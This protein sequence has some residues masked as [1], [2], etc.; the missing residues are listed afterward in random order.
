MKIICT[1]IKLWK[2]LC[3]AK[4]S[5]NLSL[6]SKTFIKA[7]T[8]LK[9]PLCSLYLWLHLNWFQQ[10]QAIQSYCYELQTNFTDV[11]HWLQSLMKKVAKKQQSI[12]KSLE[13]KK[14]LEGK[15]ILDKIYLSREKEIRF[16]KSYQCLVLERRMVF[17]SFLCYIFFVIFFF[18][19]FFCE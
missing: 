10:K 11:M 3:L 2:K 4:N 15:K 14:A 5:F 13:K 17:S 19:F 1:V 9:F 18:P 8:L 16:S 12:T 7:F 6:N